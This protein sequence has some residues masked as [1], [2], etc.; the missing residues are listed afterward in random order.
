M[1]NDPQVE[2][3]D[4]PSRILS[5]TTGASQILNLSTTT[6]QGLQGAVNIISSVLSAEHQNQINEILI[7]FNN[8]LMKNQVFLTKS[9]ILTARARTTAEL[10][11]SIDIKTIEELNETTSE[12]LGKFYKL[13]PILEG[14]L[15]DE[16]AIKRWRDI[17]AF[18]AVSSAIA[19][20]ICMGN[21]YYS[22]SGFT[23]ALKN[24]LI[25]A[26]SITGVAIPSAVVAHFAQ[27]LSK[28][29]PMIMNIKEIGIRLFELGQNFAQI[30]AISQNLSDEDDTKQ[31]FMELLKDTQNEVNKGF[32]ILKQL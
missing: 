8:M 24:L 27:H 14:K 11:A 25:A 15:K 23:K 22:T 28:M 7:G 9:L 12:L 5:I 29:E 20:S 26:G 3:S 4:I 10:M 13:N 18:L 21:A 2:W 17:F 30:K 1:N 16:R 6:I 31:M 32:E 19:C